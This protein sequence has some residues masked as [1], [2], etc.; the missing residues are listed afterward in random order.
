MLL[1]GSNEA[2]TELA[3]GFRLCLEGNCTASDIVTDRDTIRRSM[4]KI[5]KLLVDEFDEPFTEENIKGIVFYA[6]GYAVF[7]KEHIGDYEVYLIEPDEVQG[8]Y[9]P[10]KKPIILSDIY[11]NV[12]VFKSLN[13]VQKQGHSICLDLN[14]EA[15]FDAI[16]ISDSDSDNWG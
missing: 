4:G 11:K 16:L 7:L 15:K 1:S 6:S 12:Y 9:L 2:I 8:F 5:N 13:Q 3:E 10:S 14:P